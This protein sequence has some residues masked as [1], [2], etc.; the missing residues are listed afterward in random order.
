M[1]ITYNHQGNTAVWEEDTG[2]ISGPEYMVERLMDIWEFHSRPVKLTETGPEAW[3]T[4]GDDIP[5]GF[6]K[7]RRSLVPKVLPRRDSSQGS[8]RRTTN[9]T[10]G[11]F[12]R[13][14]YRDGP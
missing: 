5:P 1:K 10:G 13:G 2:L 12:P 3:P 6:K 11:G 14:P 7:V 4:L 9:Q 8:T